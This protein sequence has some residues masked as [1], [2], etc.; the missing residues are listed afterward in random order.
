MAT[1]FTNNALTALAA[2]VGV[3]DLA[4]TVEPGKGALFA[5]PTAGN[6]QIITLSDPLYTTF[7]ICYL[8][9]RTGDVLTV[10]RAKEGTSEKPW[11]IGDRVYASIT[12]GVV[13][14]FVRAD[15]PASITGQWDFGANPT[16]DG[17]PLWH[18]GNVTPADKTIP[19]SISGAWTFSS[20]PKFNAYDFVTTSGATFSGRVYLSAD[21]STDLE[22]ATKKY[23]D[24]LSH[25]HPNKQSVV[26]AS[27]A[28]V[29]IAS[30][31]SSL[32]GI[33]LASGARILLKNQ[34]NK[35]ENL[36]YIFNGVGAALTLAPDSDATG[37]ITPGTTVFVSSGSSNVGSTWTVI[38][39]DP[40]TIGT[41]EITWTQT[42]GAGQLLQG[43]GISI[44][45]NTI[46]ARINAA[47]GLMVDGS[48]I[49]M[50]TIATVVPNPDAVVT[51]TTGANVVYNTFMADAF[52]RVTKAARRDYA[53][54]G[55]ATFTGT[56]TRTTTPSADNDV[57]N[58]SYVRTA[59]ANGQTTKLPVRLVATSNITLS[60][61][62]I[63]DDV[64]GA[65][66]DRIGVVGQ[67]NK[68]QNGIYVMAAGAWARATDFSTS[69]PVY[70]NIAFTVQEGAVNSS[71]TFILTTT[72]SIS[73][74]TTALNFKRVT[75][76]GMLRTDIGS[77]IV[78]S[79]DSLTLSETGV[80][81]GTYTAATI[82]VGRDGRVTSASNNT[83]SG[84]VSVFG[85]TGVV[86]AQA[87]D[88]IFAQIGSKPTTL[89]GYG[90]TDPIAMLTSPKFTGTVTVNR[91]SANTLLPYLELATD[92]N[93][94]YLDFHAN[95]TTN[96]NYD[97][98]IYATGGTGTGT[99]SAS[100]Q[101]VASGVYLGTT[102]TNPLLDLNTYAKWKSVTFNATATDSQL[103]AYGSYLVSTSTHAGTVILPASPTA[104]MYVRLAD[105]LG[106]WA[107]RN[108]TVSRNNSRIASVEEDL[109]L[110]VKYGSVTLVYH[111]ATVGW[112]PSFG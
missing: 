107:D 26:A 62:Q 88:Y 37:D 90:I 75:G 103:E 1:L 21:P 50:A 61:V 108:V 53:E 101:F 71:Q 34:T 9:G 31:P 4:I 28:N 102:Q 69:A 5:S 66:G 68:A 98:R 25:G 85:R 49:G 3:G 29:N 110:D 63:I 65:A 95:P 67:T 14:T 60:G 87:N 96:T 12:A 104:G 59:V 35:T 84:V 86:A 58:V 97:A 7:E 82:T 112:V 19:Q 92:D 72:G 6:R 46:S 38:T 36:I 11:S 40:I 13:E 16:V 73:I 30:A 78:I 76:A 109:I 10:Q 32:D 79:G 39:P 18:A 24:A 54:L 22:A 42:S 45:G 20:L 55:G 91:D 99:G 27:T 57:T 8:T 105:V 94:S 43:N 64:Q 2:P 48:G 77:G 15:S 41:T 44:T 89:S 81:P 106:T 51:G 80:S 47:K 56:L 100:L 93:N 17:D 33:S 52:G 83:A 74:G 70:T 23:V 111:G